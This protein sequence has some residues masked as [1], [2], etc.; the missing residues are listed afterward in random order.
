MDG[1][2]AEVTDVGQVSLAQ[3]DERADSVDRL[4]LEAVVGAH[5]Q[6]QGLNRHLQL[7]E[8]EVVALGWSELNTLSVKSNDAPT[9]HWVVAAKAEL[10]KIREQVQNIE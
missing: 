8:Q 2:A 4:T 6:V 10:E 5:G 1:L 3:G 7:L 9:S